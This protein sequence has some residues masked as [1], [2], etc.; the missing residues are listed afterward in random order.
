MFFMVCNSILCYLCHTPGMSQ[1]YVWGGSNVSLDSDPQTSCLVILVLARQ[2]PLM[3]LSSLSGE[4]YMVSVAPHLV[5]GSILYLWID[6]LKSYNIPKVYALVINV[7]KV[8]KLYN[9]GAV[10]SFA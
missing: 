10:I 1:P 5:R 3:A 6:Y 8:I 2:C 7:F 4:V 9:S